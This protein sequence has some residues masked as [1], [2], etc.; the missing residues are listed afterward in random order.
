MKVIISMP[1]SLNAIK[2]AT[3]GEGHNAALSNMAAED[4][5]QFKLLNYEG[6]RA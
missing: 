3:S 5:E 6:S 2:I 4:N 1:Y